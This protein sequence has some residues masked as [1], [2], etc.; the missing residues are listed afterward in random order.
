MGIKV[1]VKVKEEVMVV[2]GVHVKVG[3]EVTVPLGVG[4]GVQ[5]MRTV[6]TALDKTL[7]MGVWPFNSPV[8]ARVSPQLL[9]VPTTV[10]APATPAAKL[11]RGQTT[12]WPVTV[13]APLAE[14]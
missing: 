3:V 2:V 14:E 7:F 13:G 4:V 5:P 1:R 8:F 6:L 10:R 11:P 12:S 9:T